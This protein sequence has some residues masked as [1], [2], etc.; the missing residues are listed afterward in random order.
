M[1]LLIPKVA[2]AAI[3]LLFDPSQINIE[4]RFGT[5]FFGLYNGMY[6]FEETRPGGYVYASHTILDNVALSNILANAGVIIFNKVGTI[7]SFAQNS[8]ISDLYHYCVFD[9]MVDTRLAELN[10]TAPFKLRLCTRSGIKSDMLKTLDNYIVDMPIDFSTVTTTCA[11]AGKPVPPIPI[12]LEMHSDADTYQFDEAAIK[13]HLLTHNQRVRTFKELI[14]Q[15]DVIADR[16]MLC[17]FCGEIAYRIDLVLSENEPPSEELILEL[18]DRTIDAHRKTHDW[19]NRARRAISVPFSSPASSSSESEDTPPLI[20]SPGHVTVNP[21]LL[22]VPAASGKAKQA[23]ILQFAFLR[24]ELEQLIPKGGHLVISRGTPAKST[25]AVNSAII[26]GDRLGALNETTI[27][28]MP[29]HSVTRSE[30]KWDAFL[31]ALHPIPAFLFNADEFRAKPYPPE[32]TAAL[33]K[34]MADKYSKKSVPVPPSA[35]VDAKSAVEKTVPMWLVIKS[36][37]GQK[38]LVQRSDG[39]QIIPEWDLNV[40]PTQLVHD[41]DIFPSY[42][43]YLKQVFLNAPASFVIDACM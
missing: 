22:P 17:D 36:R 26:T 35:N 40:T 37:R 31:T 34:M 43:D 2:G 28:Y 12:V 8:K 27:I 7:T 33:F 13:A 10:T 24:K 14:A 3:L 4:T 18:W 11:P 21:E 9:P 32:P 25:V 20:Q 30:E 16:K 5:K 29:G 1:S 23:D 41:T 39:A 6:K 15:R 19:E 42:H 38:W